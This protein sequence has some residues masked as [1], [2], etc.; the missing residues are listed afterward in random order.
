MVKTAVIRRAAPQI[1]IDCS[2][3]RAESGWKVFDVT[4]DGASLVTTYRG[5]FNGDQIARGGSTAW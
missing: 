3:E 1:P 2:M 5:T 4:I